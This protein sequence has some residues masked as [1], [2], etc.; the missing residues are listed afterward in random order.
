MN[1]TDLITPEGF[2][3]FMLAYHKRLESERSFPPLGV[4]KALHTASPI[5]GFENWQAMLAKADWSAPKKNKCVALCIKYAADEDG[6]VPTELKIFESDMAACD[7]LR[8]LTDYP[9]HAPESLDGWQEF[10]ENRL[11][12]SIIYTRQ[13]DNEP[14]SDIVIKIRYEGQH[15]S[16]HESIYTLPGGDDS[17]SVRI[18][19]FIG[20]LFREDLG[21]Q[22]TVAYTLEHCPMGEEEHPLHNTRIY[23][24]LVN[25]LVPPAALD[26]AHCVESLAGSDFERQ[27][28]SSKDFL[29]FFEAATGTTVSIQGFNV[30]GDDAKTSQGRIKDCVDHVLDMQQKYGF[31]NDEDT[32]RGA[33]EESASLLNLMLN[34]AEIKSACWKILN[35]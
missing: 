4:Q 22:E 5:F 15:Q 19:E 32:V 10:A 34:E 12:A 23:N 18:C 33:V 28:F 16:G 2:S 35:A 8:D 21:A 17:A 27:N 26:I 31:S 1:V 30:G 29:A 25:S 24:S 20:R 11:G 3:E 9:A 7:Y 13:G 14:D 6:N